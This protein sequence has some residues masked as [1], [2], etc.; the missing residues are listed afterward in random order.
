MVENALDDLDLSEEEQA[1]LNNEA[2]TNEA[3]TNEAETNET[4]ET[5]K[6]ADSD[7]E[8]NIDNEYED[9]K[10]RWSKKSPDEI[11]DGLWN[12]NKARREARKNEKSTKQDLQD[13]LDKIETAK[14][15]RLEKVAQDKKN[16]EHNF[17]VDPIKATKN[18]QIAQAEQQL[19]RGK[20]EDQ[21]KV[22]NWHTQKLYELRPDFQEHAQ[23]IVKWGL[24][25]GYS[26]EELNTRFDYRDLTIMYDNYMAET[27]N[28]SESPSEFNRAKNVNPPTSLSSVRGAKSGKNRSLKQRATEALEMSDDDFN[29]MSDKELNNILQSLDGQ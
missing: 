6:S 15:E 29:D 27:G 14:K 1:E 8:A 28:K 22:V 5:E 23:D 7:V 21:Q 2:P 16:I 26:Q 18:F 12:Q 24:A 19:D 13:V 9:F 25:K 3:E 17:Q 4:Q 11:I 10:N 20:L